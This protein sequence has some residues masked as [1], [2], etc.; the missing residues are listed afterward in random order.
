MALSIT[1]ANSVYMFTVVGLFDTPQQLQGY[2]TD[3]AFA[4]DASESAEVVK[5]V[6]GRM[7]AGF[8]PFLTNQ[9]V[10]LQADSASAFLF[11]DWIAAQIA[12]LASG[13]SGIYYANATLS[14]P[15]IGRKYTQTKGVL[16][17]VPI[18][19][20]AKKVLQARDFVITWDA[21]SAAPI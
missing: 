8:M 14:I 18:L 19:P 2:A 10:S 13:G 7:S 4:T 21:I 3:A 16:K 11:E 5:G 17:N 9:T 1:A 6:D 12:S 15:S 20:T